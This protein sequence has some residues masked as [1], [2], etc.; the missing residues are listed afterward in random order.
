MTSLLPC[1][2]CGGEAERSGTTLVRCN[3][4]MCGFGHRVSETIWNCRAPEM[5]ESLSAAW[6]RYE[7]TFGEPPHGTIKQMAA[8]LE[9]AKGSPK[10]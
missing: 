7:E 10:P 9:P 8:L 6:R 5:A 1:P 3:N 2:F 4:R